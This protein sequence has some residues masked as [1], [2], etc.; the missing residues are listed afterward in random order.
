MKSYEIYILYHTEQDAEN[1]IKQYETD[2]KSKQDY[3][4][5]VISKLLN[6]ELASE[7][8]RY[9]IEGFARSKNEIRIFCYGSKYPSVT[10]DELCDWLSLTAVH[11]IKLKT[12]FDDHST[13][14]FCIADNAKCSLQKYN[15]VYK[16]F[17]IKD[18]AEERK[19]KRAIKAKQSRKKDKPVD[20]IALQKQTEL[21]EKMDFGKDRRYKTALVRLLTKDREKK[22]LILELFNKHKNMQ[23]DND[24]MDFANDFNQV[25]TARS[26]TVSWLNHPPTQGEE[27]LVA[28][29]NFMIG[30]KFIV[31]QDDY[32]YLGFDTEALTIHSADDIDE[33]LM[34]L[35]QIFGGIGG[36]KKAWIKYRS[37]KNP[38]KERIIR[39]PVFGGSV[40]RMRII[41]EEHQ[42]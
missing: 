18:P 10:I 40:P 34:N 22:D 26:K 31:D 5:V 21:Y 12:I 7:T 28:P 3:L 16:K 36:V 33:G 1:I 30:L 13:E 39:H 27:H 6:L 42:W 8:D 41:K 14:N 32:I 37:G 15:S 20:P 29:D 2:I 35:V 9:P 23:S 24:L 4:E 17:K 25:F 38:N 11:G 19:K